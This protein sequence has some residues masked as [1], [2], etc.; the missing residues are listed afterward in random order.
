MSTLSPNALQYKIDLRA[1]A[2]ATEYMEITDDVK[3]YTSYDQNMW[4]DNVKVYHFGDSPIKLVV[5]P[6][7]E[8]LVINSRGQK[9]DSDVYLCEDIDRP[10]FYHN[11]KLTL[12]LWGQSEENILTVGKEYSVHYFMPKDIIKLIVKHGVDHK[13]ELPF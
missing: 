9:M 11:D 8:N 5:N 4:S 2:E 12:S 10:L 1:V 13:I 6:H 7:D 3:V